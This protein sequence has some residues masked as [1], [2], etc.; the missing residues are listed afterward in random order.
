M[1][2]T[3]AGIG[4]LRL[5][6]IPVRRALARRA[7]EALSETDVEQVREAGFVVRK[8][9][10]ELRR[11]EGFLCHAP[12][13]SPSRYVCKGDRRPTLQVMVETGWGSCR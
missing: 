13:Y 4:A 12:S 8:L 5:D 9:A 6:P 3:L 11:R 7:S 1:A 10:E 2:S